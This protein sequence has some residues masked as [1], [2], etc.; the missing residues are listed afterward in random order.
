MSEI[1]A[2]LKDYPAIKRAYDKSH[3]D[4]ALLTLTLDEAAQPPALILMLDGRLQPVLFGSDRIISYLQHGYNRIQRLCPL[5]HWR[6]CKTEKCA[7]YVV[8]GITGD[9]VHIWNHMQ[10]TA[11]SGG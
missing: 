10:A 1:R 4:K 2:N 8:K 7:F 5:N 11:P 3:F 6:K 9:C